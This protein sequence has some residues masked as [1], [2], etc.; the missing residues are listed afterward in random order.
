MACEQRRFGQVYLQ[1]RL[2]RWF[3]DR[4]RVFVYH[5][6]SQPETDLQ[7]RDLATTGCRYRGWTMLSN[8]HRGEIWTYPAQKHL[9]MV[10]MLVSR[11]SLILRKDWQQIMRDK[12]RKEREYL[13]QMRRAIKHH[14][15]QFAW[16]DDERS[17]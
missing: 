14:G 4:R 8:F 9:T 12:I 10:Q 1:H 7:W 13:R 16:W 2:D 6:I 5:Y 11:D 17:R 3:A 15:E